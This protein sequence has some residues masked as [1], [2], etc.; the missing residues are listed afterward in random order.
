MMFESDT[1][2]VATYQRSDVTT[3]QRRD[4]PTSRCGNV[5]T[6]RRR[7]VGFEPSRYVATLTRRDVKDCWCLVHYVSCMVLHKFRTHY[8]YMFEIE[9]C[10][11]KLNRSALKF[12]ESWISK[13]HVE[14]T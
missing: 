8:S 10:E 13:N 2:N 1:P 12:L 4:V 11:L 6:W 7:D 14:I 3:L 5:T 9:M